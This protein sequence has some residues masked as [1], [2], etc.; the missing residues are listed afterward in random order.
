[1]TKL[2]GPEGITIEIPF[3]FENDEEFYDYLDHI[4]EGLKN[5][6]HNINAIVTYDATNL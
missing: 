1:M 5:V 4:A 6:R 3:D 2:R